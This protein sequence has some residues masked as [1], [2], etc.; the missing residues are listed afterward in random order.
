M[1]NAGLKGH[2]NLWMFFQ[3][4]VNAMHLFQ[5]GRVESDVD[6]NEFLAFGV[7]D[8]NVLPRRVRCVFA[9][10]FI[11]QFNKLLGVVAHC[12]EFEIAGKFNQALVV[13]GV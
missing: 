11:D 7:V 3:V 13:G 10:D 2:Q 4:A 8:V 12:L 6:G 5:A 1:I 9:G